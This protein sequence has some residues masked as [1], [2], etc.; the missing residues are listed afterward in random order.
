MNTSKILFICTTLLILASCKVENSTSFPSEQEVTS[1]MNEAVLNSDL[2]AIVAIAINK[3][4]EKI[5]YQH[6]RAIWNEDTD[7]TS[8]HI[9]RIWSMTKL[10]TSIAALQCVENDLIGIDED[11]TNVLP[12]MCK[13]PILSD[14]EMIEP[15]NKITLRHLLTH[16]SGFGY[17]GYTVNMDGFNDENWNYEDAPRHFESGTNFLYGENITKPLGMNRTFFNVPDSLNSLI[18]SNGNRGND[19]QEKLKETP[20]RIPNSR[21]T[22]FSGGGGLF[23]TPSDYTKLLQCLL[24]E[25][26]YPDGRIL[27]KKTVVE[28]TKNQIGDISLNPEG[29]YFDSATCC[30]F[31]GLMDENSKW[32]LAFLIDNDSKDY[33][34]QAGTVL[35]GGYMNTYF[36]IDFKSGIAASIYSQHIPFNHYETTTLFDSFSEIVYS[37]N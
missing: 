27:R 10:I 35:W 5:T 3:N 19:G 16:T 12:E 28:M 17:S 14:G 8:D 15:K 30:N 6:G 4:G 23:S 29:W 33:G 22:N 26:K 2:P 7:V 31:N 24:N 32:G 13:I 20:D 18:V 9:F 34:R 25:G 21:V 36:Y 1:L 11:L 37:K